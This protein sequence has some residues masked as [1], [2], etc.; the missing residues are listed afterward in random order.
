MNLRIKPMRTNELRAKFTNSFIEEFGDIGKAG[1]AFP[2]KPD[3]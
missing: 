3:A 1:I 2:R